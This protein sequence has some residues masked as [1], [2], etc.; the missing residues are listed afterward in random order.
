MRSILLVL[1]LAA[2]VS[3]VASIPSYTNPMSTAHR[4]KQETVLVTFVNRT[5]QEREVR[6]GNEQYVVRY[7]SQFHLYLPV[8]TA[9]SVYSNQNSKINGQQVVLVSADAWTRPVFLK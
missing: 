3:A 6:I 1:A 2:P 8:G 5:S 7:N 4:A 9:V